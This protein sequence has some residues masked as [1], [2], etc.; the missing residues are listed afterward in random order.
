MSAKAMGAFAR[1]RTVSWGLNF[2]SHLL[3][4]NSK[5][6]CPFALLKLRLTTSSDVGNFD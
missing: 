4:V 6:L 5:L 1:G 2:A 3:P